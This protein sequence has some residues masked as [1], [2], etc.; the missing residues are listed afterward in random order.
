MVCF[1]PHGNRFS[2]ERNNLRRKIHIIIHTIKLQ[3]LSAYRIINPNRVITPRIAIYTQNSARGP[4]VLILE[5]WHWA[6]EASDAALR[7]LLA[8]ISPYRLLVV[9]LYRP[10]YEHSWSG[11]GQQTSLPLKPLETAQSEAI[12]R[13]VLNA[14]RLP[15][16]LGE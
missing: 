10:E 9:V 14:E 12:A 16:G 11:L 7:Y 1:E 3:R 2:T 4:M 5:D 15:E 6:D 13:A 8:L